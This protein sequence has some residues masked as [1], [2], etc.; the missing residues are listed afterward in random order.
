MAK[1]K[2]KIEE[3]LSNT[4]L[5]IEIP[6]LEL[7]SVDLLQKTQIIKR[8]KTGEEE[9]RENNY[10]IKINRSNINK[11]S[12]G[13]LAKNLQQLF[14]MSFIPFNWESQTFTYYTSKYTGDD[15]FKKQ[16]LNNIFDYLKEFEEKYKIEKASSLAVF[17]KEKLVFN[18][19]KDD[20]IVVKYHHGL[21]S[22][23]VLATNFLG[24][25]KYSILANASKEKG[26]LESS[27]IESTFFDGLYEHK[28]RSKKM[29]F[30]INSY[31]YEHVKKLIEIKKEEVS[32][33][34]KEQTKVVEENKATFVSYEEKNI[35]GFKLKFDEEKKCFNF[36]CRGYAEPTS[37]YGE[38]P[39]RSLL[40][41]WAL[42][43]IL[44]EEVID[45]NV[46]TNLDESEI[47]ETHMHSYEI[48]LD[49]HLKVLLDIRKES[50]L[51]E[52]SLW[53]P[54][55]NWERLEKMYHRFLKNNELFGREE[56]SIKLVEANFLLRGSSGVNL[57]TY[58]AIYLNEKGNAFFIYSY[59]SAISRYTYEEDK[60]TIKKTIPASTTMRGV[61]ISFEE[62]NNFL[63]NHPLST[64]IKMNTIFLNSEIWMRDNN[65]NTL[66]TDEERQSAF[67]NI[68]M[69][70][71]IRNETATVKKA[72][73]NKI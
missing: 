7:F 70:A 47:K 27:Q 25:E 48:D 35:F 69:H 28:N 39:D 20:E 19:Y 65:G 2:E 11:S 41:R 14:G 1:H 72:K 4:F 45:K 58:P 66:L 30:M 17:N 50:S 36:Y 53:V 54:A 55:D 56:K 3:L 18:D 59:R 46:P 42:N 24:K 52:K 8:V 32:Q 26:S 22:F 61:P 60:V 13:E 73:V 49:N 68:Y 23:I 12:H 9:S 31:D 44:S 67:D 6:Q 10:T 63:N 15:N 62:L 34:L 40:A 43:F 16:Q 51:R 38:A 5:G 33:F 29:Y 37:D 64:H 21:D 71:K 57:K